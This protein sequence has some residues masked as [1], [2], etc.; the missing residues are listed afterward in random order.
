M[1]RNLFPDVEIHGGLAFQAREQHFALV[2]SDTTFSDH[3][4]DGRT[5]LCIC[6]R[7]VFLHVAVPMVSVGSLESRCH[8]QAYFP[9]QPAHLAP[10]TGHTMS[11]V[12]P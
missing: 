11:E 5:V 4:Q 1:Y 10:D 9:A 8:L 2:G 6:R 12:I 7:P 3:A